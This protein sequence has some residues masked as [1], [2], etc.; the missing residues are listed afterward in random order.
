MR[1]KRGATWR[2]VARIGLASRAVIYLPLAAL[3]VELALTEGRSGETDQGGALR[4]I[5]ATLLGTAFLCVFAF[6][7]VCYTAWR[8]SEAA[9]GRHVEDLSTADRVKA[10]VEGTCYLPFAVMAIAVAVGDDKRTHQ[11]GTYRSVSAEVMRTTF[12]QV[13]V[14]AVGAGVVIVGCYLF[15]EGPRRSF[16][17][18]L[19]FDNARESWR[20]ITFT[21]GIVGS[22][23]RGA[24]FALTGVLV[25]VAAA[26]ATP[27]KAG[28]IDAALRT[29]A[30]APYGRIVLLIAAVGIAA[31]GVFALAESRWRQ[32]V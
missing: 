19:D 1:L 13:L 31:F 10:F 27:A 21:C 14:G 9:L 16:A 8:W 3:M 26:T 2:A 23:A 24:V 29:V 12:G 30:R 32:V 22:V 7:A 5:G 28:G 6:G 4:D 17:A 15:S 11:A 25:I 20:R 18:D